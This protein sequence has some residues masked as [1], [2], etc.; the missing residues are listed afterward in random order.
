MIKDQCDNCN[1]QGTFNCSLNV[2]FNGLTCDMYSKR[3]SLE[4]T[5]ENTER[6]VDGVE[7]GTN[8]NQS[9]GSYKIDLVKHC[10]NKSVQV[11]YT[12]Q[13]N[14]S[15]RNEDNTLITSEYLK[16]N[17]KIHGWLSF[18]LFLMVWVA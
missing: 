12:I 7:T 14:D 1:K 6:T 4:K 10:D 3:I 16:N 13:E 15:N 11:D 8:D 18:F 9:S 2:V 17:T 5:T